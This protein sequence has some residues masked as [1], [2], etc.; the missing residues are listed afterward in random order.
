MAQNISVTDGNRTLLS[1]QVIRGLSAL[2]IA[3]FHTSVIMGRP[4]YGAVQVFVWQT[5]RCWMGVN[6]FFVLS[7]FI[8]FFAHGKDVGRPRRLSGYAWRRMC[9]VYPVYWLFLS[10]FIFAALSGYGYQ[11][12]RLTLGDLMSAYTLVHWIDNPTLPL[13]VAWTLVF[14]ISFY[15]M[16]AILIVS[17]RLGA[18]AFGLWLAVILIASFM[19][20]LRMGWMSMWNVNFFYGAAAYWLFKHLD[21]RWALPILAAGAAILAI[22]II[23][24]PGYANVEIQ[25]STPF[26]LMLVGLPWCLILLGLAL[27]ERRY[28]F[29]PPRFL[30]LLG[31]ASFATY[32][33]HSAV[34]SAMCQLVHHHVA[35]LLPAQVAFA[36]ILGTAMTVGVIGH[37]VVERPVLG[38]IKRLDLHRQVRSD[39]RAPTRELASSA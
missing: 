10:A 31:E 36:L 12:F 27:A 15:M 1:L 24:H 14:E 25:Q 16:F 19:G 35:D 11:S 8:I 2:A 7:G 28:Q 3:A 6:L 38:L 13:K 37:Y 17:R 26:W 5:S 18:L 9:R 34:I 30:V 23:G 39:R 29:Q 32:L 4:Q 33:I 21:N 20:S 22:L